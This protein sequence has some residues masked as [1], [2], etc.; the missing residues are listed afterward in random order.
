MIFL[1]KILMEWMLRYPT[2]AFIIDI[3]STTIFVLFILI[4]IYWKIFFVT[5][6]SN[7]MVRRRSK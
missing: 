5:T 6:P 3:V 4:C 1:G 2:S 7:P